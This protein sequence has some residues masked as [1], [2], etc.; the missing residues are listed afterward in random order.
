MRKPEIVVEL[1]EGRVQALLH[2]L[3]ELADDAG[4]LYNDLAVWRVLRCPLHVLLK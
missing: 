4:K 1:L 3:V 2:F